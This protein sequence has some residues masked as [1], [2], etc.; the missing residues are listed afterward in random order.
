MTEQPLDLRRSMHLVRRHWIAVCAIAVLGGLAGGAYTL[1]SP[2]LVSSSALVE[3]PAIGSGTQ[4]QAIIAGSDENV[5]ATAASRL[6]HGMSVLRLRKMI[7]VSVLAPGVLEFTAQGKT[8]AGAEHTANAVVDSYITYIGST[9][10]AA[11][12]QA[13]IVAPATIATGPS[14]VTSIATSAAI[15]ALAAALVGA[16][17]AVAL[18]RRDRQLRQRDEIADAIGLPVL[19]SM[20][21]DHPNS[22][23]RWRGLLENY[24]PSAADAWRLRST[25]HHLGLTD[26]AAGSPGNSRGRSLTVISLSSDKRA[27]AIGPQLAVY[28]SSLNLPTLLVIGPQQD[29]GPTANLR[30]ACAAVVP[31]SRRPGGLRLAVADNGQL[32]QLPEA[33]LTVVVAVVDGRAPQF[34]STISTDVAILGVSAGA[35]TADQLARVAA[36]V[37]AAGFEID[38]ILVADPEETDPTT[39][40]IPRIGRHV[41]QMRPTRLTGTTT[42]AGL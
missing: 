5:F 6:G 9:D 38:G 26:L 34:E 12:G 41:R 42:E 37:G 14:L 10:S 19:A 30:T 4:T 36:S 20:T 33:M 40:R 13:R 3:V 18:S 17:G 16:V 22:V 23:A 7:K 28:A 35:P 8:A 15:G 39:G 25:L 21:V 29:V 27:L 1:H 32:T 31:S 24:R 2:P 11:Y